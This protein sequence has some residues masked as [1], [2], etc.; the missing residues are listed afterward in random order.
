MTDVIALNNKAV[1]EIVC[2]STFYDETV[3]SRPSKLS[4]SFYIRIIHN[5]FI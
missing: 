5:G 2:L 4:K 3:C 1:K